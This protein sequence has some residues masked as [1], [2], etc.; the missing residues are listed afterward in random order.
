MSKFVD[1]IGAFNYELFRKPNERVEIVAV[2]KIGKSE[3]VK[4]LFD[5]KVGK[6]SKYVSTEIYPDISVTTI[7]KALGDLVKEGYII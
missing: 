1:I 4:D 5:K 3:R 6:I 2:D 7:E